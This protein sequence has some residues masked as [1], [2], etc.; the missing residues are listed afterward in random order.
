M[1][2]SS[3]YSEHER[4]SCRHLCCRNTRPP[5]AVWLDRSPYPPVLPRPVCLQYPLCAA[6]S[7]VVEECSCVSNR[8]R[9]AR[10]A[11]AN[12]INGRGVVASGDLDATT[13][14]W[15]SPAELMRGDPITRTPRRFPKT[16]KMA[17]LS[18]FPPF[19]SPFCLPP[20]PCV[21]SFSLL[22]TADSR[23]VSLCIKPR[24]CP[25]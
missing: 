3:S 5:E 1:D 17:R 14:Q 8:A 10:I 15:E 4:P 19:P 7:Y 25:T 2:Q 16:I 11:E 12:R 18:Q 23:F 21:R 6:G 9:A 20:S 13:N 22:K 24:A